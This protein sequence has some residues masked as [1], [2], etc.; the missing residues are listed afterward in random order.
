M[1]DRDDPRDRD[2]GPRDRHDIYDPRW[3]DDARE[4]DEDWRE[5]DRDR[6]HD[7][8]DVFVHDLDLPRGLEREIV[9]DERDRSRPRELMHDA[10]LYRA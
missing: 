7:P 4:R 8:R 10:S 6:D 3:K 2:G 9:L 5:P 1:F